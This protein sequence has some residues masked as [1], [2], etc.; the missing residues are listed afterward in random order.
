M[1]VYDNIIVAL[2]NTDSINIRW[3]IVVAIIATMAAIG[4]AIF[5]F[6]ANKQAKLIAMQS[7]VVTLFEYWKG[8]HAIDPQNPVDTHV[9]QALNIL[10]FTATVWNHNIA[11][12]QLVY[13]DYWDSY[14]NLYESIA[15]IPLMNR[16][17]KSGKELLKKGVI[18]AYNEMSIYNTKTLNK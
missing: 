18:R 6:Q 8:V 11:D 15:L 10:A 12:R 2:S 3:E 4:S 17:S 14:K 16:F 13:E 1:H 7:H 5:T 9:V